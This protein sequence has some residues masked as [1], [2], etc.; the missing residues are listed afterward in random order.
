MTDLQKRIDE[1][2]KTIEELLLD[3]H[4][5]RIAITTISTAWNSLAKQPGMLG[6]SYDKAFKSASPVEFENPVNE[7]YAEELHKR[8]VAL[9]SKS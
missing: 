6:D 1:L 9:L 2:E 7:G 5:A 4:A 3:Q 8:V